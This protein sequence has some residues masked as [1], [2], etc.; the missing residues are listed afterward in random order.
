M[1]FLDSDPLS[2]SVTN[3]AAKNQPIVYVGE[4]A[5][6]TVTLTNNTGSAIPLTT[7]QQASTLEVFLPTFYTWSQVQQMTLAVTDWKPAQDA[8][9]Q[10][11]MLT[12]TGAETKWQNGASIA[13]TISNALCSNQPTTD[14]IQVNPSNLGAG[15]PLQV[16]TPISLANPPQPGN[17]TLS[18]TLYP[19]LNSQGTVFV[20]PT[21]DPLPNTLFLNFKNTGKDPIY[22]GTQM[23]T[24]TPQ[25]KISFVYG[26]TAGALAPN[27]DPTSPPIGSAWN[28]KAAVNVGTGWQP[29]PPAVSGQSPPVWVLKPTNTNKQI[30]G[31]GENANVTFA[32]SNIVSFTPPG[33]TQM[34]VLFT[35][36]QQTET[37]AYDD[38]TFVVDISKQSAPPTR[39]LVN[40]FSPTPE[41]TVYSPTDPVTVDLQWA[42]FDVPAVTLL[43]SFP[44]ID[45]VPI[46]YPNFT[47]V[48]YDSTS[49]TIPGVTQSGPVVFTLQAF[50]AVGNY[51]NSMQFVAYIQANVFV[52]PRDS[53]VYPAILAGKTLWMAQNLNFDAADSHCYNDDGDNAP[54]YGRLYSAT[55]A[56]QVP[57]GWRLPTQ[58]D[59]LALINLYGT[60]QQAYTALIAGGPSKFNAQLGGMRD[61]VGTYTDLT[62]FGYYWTASEGS[63]SDQQMYVQFDG[64]HGAVSTGASYPDSFYVSVRY[65]R[66]L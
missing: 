29:L 4:S 35:G 40:F 24:G 10:S 54:Q 47:P 38:Q 18:D 44:G 48:A 56:Q 39:G 13:I 53:Q 55:A 61:N 32:F 33:H 51:L 42:M 9:D 19:S 49:I 41:Y 8:Q 37:K 25:V 59:W 62:S 12:Y 58:A 23:W 2:L 7:G 6:L 28:I 20:S 21:N 57:A 17:A 34:T 14:A 16:S 65:V 31:T 66:D 52:D 22:N 11:W 60:P 36:F 64:S 15:V 3:A 30:I 26:R 27:D 5:T 63:S 50:D 1:P 43:T 45:R 46:K